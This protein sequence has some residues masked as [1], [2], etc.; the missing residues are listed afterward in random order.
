MATNLETSIRNPIAVREALRHACDRGELLLLVTPYL[1]FESNFL[2]LDQEDLWVT[3][4]MSRED[5][6]FGLRSPDLRIRFPFGHQ[7]FEAAT[8][9]RSL[10]SVRGR[11]ALALAIP[12][13]MNVDD[14]RASYRVERVGRLMA[15]FSSRR[16]DLLMANVVNISTSGVRIYAQ[17]DFEDGDV[18]V[19]D[20]IHIAL[21]VTPEIDIN[22]KAKVRFVKDRVLGLEFRPRPDGPLLDAFSRWVFQ[23][24]EEEFQLHSAKEEAGK[25]PSKVA[26]PR[27]MA[28]LVLVGGDPELEER[29]RG[30]LTDLPPLDRVP[31]GSQTMKDLAASARSLVIL[32]VPSLAMEDRKRARILLETLGGRVPFVLLGTGV[33]SAGLAEL[34]AETRAVAAYNLGQASTGF[35]PRLLQGILRKHFPA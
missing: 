5:A 3:A 16:F 33:D 9:L 28:T 27:A 26:A 6:L 23:K 15:T 35:F 12:D 17:G 20:I 31:P 4:L 11:N 25:E 32:H 22:C 14:Y 21:T 29:L 13:I 7:F 10:G 30:M 8:R 19:D 2:R 1:R 18:L 24:Q 34:A